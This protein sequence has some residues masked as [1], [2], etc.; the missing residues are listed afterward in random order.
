MKTSKINQILNTKWNNYISDEHPIDRRMQIIKK[1]DIYGMTTE[2]IQFLINELVSKFGKNGVYLEIGTF[3]GS[4]LLSAA[5]FNPTTKCIGIDNFSQ[6]KNSPQNMDIL[7]NNLNKFDIKNIEFYNLD[8]QIALKKLKLDKPS[9]DITIFFYDGNHSYHHQLNALN[10]VLNHLSKKC[11]ILID[12]INWKPVEISALQ[13]LKYHRDF[14]SVLKIKT[15]TNLALEK[16]GA[17]TWWNGFE[18]ITRGI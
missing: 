16:K 9:C 7:N 15:K 10:L 18:V 3:F 5:L 2:N 6:F 4:S 13:F 14:N 1:N 11:I 12:D 8:Y 17:I